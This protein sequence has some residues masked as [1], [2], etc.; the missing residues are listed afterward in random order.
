MTWRGSAVPLSDVPLQDR[1]R[2]KSGRG[3]TR[4]NAHASV[5][6]LPDI[7]NNRRRRI[8]E[9]SG[10]ASGAR[11]WVTV[12]L[13]SNLRRRGSQSYGE[14][15]QCSVRIACTEPNVPCAYRVRMVYT[16]AAE[17]AL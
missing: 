6:A 9:T 17:H 13:R 11:C 1:P 7:E 16:L 2:R 10:I 5:A 8:D 15:C 4:S 14:I 12:L 3:Q